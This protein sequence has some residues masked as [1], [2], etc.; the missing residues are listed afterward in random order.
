MHRGKY[1]IS[2]ALKYYHK[3]MKW[4]FAFSDIHDKTIVHA[5]I[6]NEPEPVRPVCKWKQ[7]RAAF[8]RGATTT[9]PTEINVVLAGKNWGREL[10]R[11]CFTFLP[12]HMKVQIA[13]YHWLPPQEQNKASS[14]RSGI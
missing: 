3:D 8:P 2:T 1:M 7:K 13:G 9:E 5:F 11:N 12:P 4:G 10:C 6:R 14:G